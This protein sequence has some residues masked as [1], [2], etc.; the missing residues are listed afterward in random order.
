VGH[1]VAA[2]AEYHPRESVLGVSLQVGYDSRKGSFDQEI[3]LLIPCRLIHHPDLCYRG[4]N[5]R[6]A[7]FKSGFYLYGGPGCFQLD[8]IINYKQGQIPIPLE[9]RTMLI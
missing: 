5:L 2:L 8:Q 9:M 7:P 3:T 1:Y 6:V 4:A